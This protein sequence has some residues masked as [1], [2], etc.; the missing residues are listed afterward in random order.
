MKLFWIIIYSVVS[1]SDGFFL[2]IKSFQ[3]I[4][5]IKTKPT[6]LGNYSSNYVR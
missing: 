6:D 5:G 2:M 4:N 1:Q 3:K